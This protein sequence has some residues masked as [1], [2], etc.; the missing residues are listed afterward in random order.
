MTVGTAS[1]AVV[2]LFAW[3]LLTDQRRQLH[4]A[5]IQ[6]ADQLSETIKKST[7]HDMMD[8]DLDDVFRMIRTI[9]E[10]PG[11][12]KVRIF[13]K[14]GEV[15]YST[16]EEEI[17]TS[18]DL[19]AEAC[20]ACHASDQPLSHVDI[21]D[22]ARVFN[23]ASDRSLLGII[24]PIYNEP[25]C[26]D[27]IC[28]YHP[29]GQKVL[30]VLDITMNLSDVEAVLRETRN[31]TLAAVL[32]TFTVLGLLSYLFIRRR[33][34]KPVYSLVKACKQV[35]AGDLSPSVETD[36][37]NELGLLSRSFNEMTHKLAEAQMQIS[38]SDRLASVGRL[39]A[40]V[41]HEINNPLTGVLTYSSFLL[42]QAEDVDRGQLKDDLE[43]VVRETKR[44]RDIVKG[45]LD[46]SRQSAVTMRPLDL[47]EVIRRSFDVLANQASLKDVQLDRELTPD[48]PKVHGDPNQLQQVVVNLMVNALDAVDA[49]GRVTVA[50]RTVT[51]PARGHAEIRKAF[52]PEGCSLVDPE[53]R[54]RNTPAI[55][56]KYRDDEGPGMLHIDPVYGRRNHVFERELAAGRRI[57]AACPKCGVSL[58]RENRDCP[59][60]G[61]RLFAVDTD[62]R[63]PVYWC[64]RKGCGYTAWEDGDTEPKKGFVEVEVADNGMGIEPERMDR[65]FEPFHTT[66]GNRGTGLGLAVSWG[67]VS[68][69]R[70]VIR[71]ESEPGKGTRFRVRIPLEDPGALDGPDSS[72]NPESTANGTGDVGGECP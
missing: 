4:D 59:E 34:L 58:L 18:V 11:I 38:Q 61:D 44:C 31:Q 24:N 19:R 47:N 66:K 17:G 54:I 49:G 13:E 15:I 52:C 10:Q 68:R 1:V 23:T 69:H 21:P 5:K 72:E 25:G 37:V 62:E 65:I 20:Y 6:C 40:G 71:V 70:G 30:G 55:T 42:K 12:E 53:Y 7:R 63:G 33:I 28:H 27:S 46:F 14:S 41:A 45:L 39:A 64:A 60:C 43:V 36:Q 35:A 26:S 67:I 56:V 29:E 32:I 2:L 8:N 3:V 9:G 57:Q 50:S 16:R 22:R 51:V 48:L